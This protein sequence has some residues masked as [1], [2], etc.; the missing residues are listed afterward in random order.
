MICAGLNADKKG[1]CKGDIGGPMV[2]KTGGVWVQAGV[3]TF[4]KVCSTSYSPGVSAGVSMYES[5]IKTQITSD[6][7]GFVT[8]PY[9]DLSKGNSCLLTTVMCFS[10]MMTM[11]C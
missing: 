1:F 6:Q 7:P 3:M 4:G 8:N 9:V 11:L 10:V 5:W 2:L